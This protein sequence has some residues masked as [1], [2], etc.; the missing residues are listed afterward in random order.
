MS[1]ANGVIK[2]GEK[3]PCPVDNQG[4]FTEEV[5]DFKGLYVKVRY[6]HTVPHIAVCRIITLINFFQTLN[7]KDFHVCTVKYLILHGITYVRFLVHCLKL[8]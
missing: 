7:F 3:V 1:I 2:K 6:S 5:T 8:S 4:Q